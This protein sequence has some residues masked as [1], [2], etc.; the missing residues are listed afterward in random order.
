MCGLVAGCIWRFDCSVMYRLLARHFPCRSA[1]IWQYLRSSCR[2]K[3]SHDPGLSQHSL[4]HFSGLDKNRIYIIVI[5][6]HIADGFGRC[7]RATRSTISSSYD[8]DVEIPDPTSKIPVRAKQFPVRREAGVAQHLGV[9]SQIGV[10]HG[11]NDCKSTKIPVIFPV[12]RNAIA[13]G[14]SELVM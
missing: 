14:L 1:A 12:G 8:A 7:R 10:A 5:G 11:R 13:A 3:P 2:V 4:V 9:A 6:C